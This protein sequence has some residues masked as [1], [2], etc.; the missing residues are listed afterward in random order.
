MVQVR[1]TDGELTVWWPDKDQPVATLTASWRPTLNRGTGRP[2][3]KDIISRLPRLQ[4]PRTGTRP[5][6]PPFRRHRLTSISP[7]GC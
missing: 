3:A 2:V 6:N 4:D 1:E 7:R 5:I